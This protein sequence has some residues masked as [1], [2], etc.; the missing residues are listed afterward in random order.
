MSVIG[1]CFATSVATVL[2][3]E[4]VDVDGGAAIGL[5]TDLKPPI[6]EST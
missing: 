1:A 6:C 5:L 2:C 3:D 4:A